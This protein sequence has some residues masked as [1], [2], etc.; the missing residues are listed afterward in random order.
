MRGHV[1]PLDMLGGLIMEDQKPMQS[2]LNAE[3]MYFSSL[4]VG[5]R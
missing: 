4:H 1:V 2:G 5:Q 3:E